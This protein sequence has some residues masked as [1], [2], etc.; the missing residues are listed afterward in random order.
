MIKEPK[1]KFCGGNK[2][3]DKFTE[4]LLDELEDEN[5]QSAIARRKKNMELLENMAME[6][7]L[8]NMRKK[9][10][11]EREPD[12]TEYKDDQTLAWDTFIKSKEGQSYLATRFEICKAVGKVLGEH[13]SLSDEQATEKLST[14]VFWERYHLKSNVNAQPNKKY[15]P[16]LLDE[17]SAKLGACTFDASKWDEIDFAKNIAKHIEDV[18]LKNSSNELIERLS[19]AYLYAN[20]TQFVDVSNEKIEKDKEELI[21]YV[22]ADKMCYGVLSYQEDKFSYFYQAGTNAND[23]GENDRD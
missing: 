4:A 12:L 8:E 9:F 18:E 17:F 23:D 2:M 10:K 20:K 1:F 16:L 21:K 3:E 22:V 7:L 14:A 13:F 6:E 5:S 11:A 15:L 19:R